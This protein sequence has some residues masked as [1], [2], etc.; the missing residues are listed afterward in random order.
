MKTNTAIIICAAVVAC[1]FILGGAYKY[2]YKE[3]HTVV[4]TGLG[5]EEFVSDLIV[6]RGWIVADN[7]SITDGYAK[8]E[9]NK[10]KVQE[11]ITS[12]GISEDDIVFMF[13]DSYKNTE[14]I[15]QNG[16]YVGQRFTGYTLRQQFSVE[17]TDVE[18]VENISREISALLAQGVQLESSQPDYYYSKLDDLKLQLIEKSTVDA[19]A[20]AEKIAT[21]SG[22]KLRKLKSARMGVFQI[23]GANANEEFSAGGNFN[24]SSKN[25]KARITMRLEYTIK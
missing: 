5:E 14:P 18:A 21:Q 17:S 9:A 22:A 7:L 16:N 4:V 8:L 25:K 3:Q 24:T 10:R 13:V 15:Y 23:T 2:K 1:A 6:W 12:R 19:K 11:F 20:R